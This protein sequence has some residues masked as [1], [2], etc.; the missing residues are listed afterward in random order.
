M[1]FVS[2]RCRRI[3]QIVSALIGVN[4]REIIFVRFADFN[5]CCQMNWVTCPELGLYKK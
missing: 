2:R 1:I 4:L 5:I 3:P